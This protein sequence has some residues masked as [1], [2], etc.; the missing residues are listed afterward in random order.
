MATATQAQ[1]LAAVIYDDPTKSRV[2][3]PEHFPHRNETVIKIETFSC[4][5]WGDNVHHNVMTALS[6]GLTFG[7][8]PPLEHW[9]TVLT[10]DRRNFFV[11]QFFADNAVTVHKFPTLTECDVFG[12]KGAGKNAGNRF[13]T[14]RNLSARDLNLNLQDVIDT[15]V[16][17]DLRYKM[18]SNNCQHFCIDLFKTLVGDQQYS[19][20]L[21]IKP[22]KTNLFKRL[23]TRAS[24]WFL[25]LREAVSKLLKSH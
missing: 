13:Q 12:I 25:S 7:K 11:L 23:F 10:T 9:W 22:P 14:L 19:E 15:L 20:S 8:A 4:R 18:M 21:K 17:L 2:Y 24:K 5:F 3:E 16:L 1:A 6:K